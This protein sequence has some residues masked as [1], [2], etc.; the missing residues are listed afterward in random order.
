MP[1]RKV[2]FVPQQIYHLYNRSIGNKPIFT[3]KRNCERALLTLFYYQYYPRPSS[4][5]HFLTSSDEEKERK[6]LIF[7]KAKKTVEILAFSLMENHF[8]L[9]IKEKRKQGISRFLSNFQNSY[10]RY[11]NLFHKT[12]G[13]L[14][15]GQF[16]AVRIIT[17]D[18][19]LHVSR[20][21]HLNPY[22]SFIVKDFDQLKKYSWSSLPD[23]LTITKSNICEKEI[24]LSYF[25]SVE[26]FEKFIFNQKD[27]QRELQTIKHLVLDQN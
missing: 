21:I 5:S 7:K 10:T 27:Y 26:S 9:L 24:L 2:I 20:Y 16:K 6:L 3:Y 25:K 19:L 13:Y 14:F 17:D 11:F 4:L 1:A 18:Q 15:E 22:S 23:Y 12:K 8:H